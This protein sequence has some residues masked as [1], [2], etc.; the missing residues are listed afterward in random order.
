ME[1]RPDADD[2][3]DDR[4][5]VQQR[6]VLSEPGS[7]G[8]PCCQKQQHRNVTGAG[9]HR[10]VRTQLVLGR[11]LPI[12]GIFE[13]AHDNSPRCSICNTHLKLCRVVL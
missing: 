2:E 5:R 6:V 9:E 1:H 11:H 10:Q 13:F 12:H 8:G 3:Q 7:Q 4:D